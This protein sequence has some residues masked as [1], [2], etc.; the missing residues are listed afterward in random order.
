MKGANK[1]RYLAYLA[2]SEPFLS[3]PAIPDMLSYSLARWSWLVAFL[4]LVLPPL[5]TPIP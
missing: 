2:N 1:D 4:P 3:V 5:L